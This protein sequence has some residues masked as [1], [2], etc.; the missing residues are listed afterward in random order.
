[1]VLKYRYVFLISDY[2][3]FWLL[4]VVLATIAFVVTMIKNQKRRR[5]LELEEKSWYEPLDTPEEK[6]DH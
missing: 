6:K 5:M 3:F 4:A 2:S 1:M